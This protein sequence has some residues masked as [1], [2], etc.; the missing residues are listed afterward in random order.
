MKPHLS[1]PRVHFCPLGSSCKAHGCWC[2]GGRAA[3]GHTKSL[4]DTASGQR[5]A[6]ARAKRLSSRS[7]VR[8]AQVRGEP[9]PR[10][11]M[12]CSN[13]PP[14]NLTQA[15]IRMCTLLTTVHVPG[16]LIFSSIS[17]TLALSSLQQFY[18][19]DTVIILILLKRKLRFREVR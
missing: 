8:Q 19:V 14:Q 18:Q 12:C 10:W 17:D 15:I 11:K 3:F 7:R 4:E 5:K 6:T 2:T 9:D 1:I 13:P 16:I